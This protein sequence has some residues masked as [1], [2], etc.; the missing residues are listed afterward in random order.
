MSDRR[1]GNVRVEGDMAVIRIPIEE[2]HGFRVALASCGCVGA[3]SLG[4]EK[5]RE[6][7]ARALGKAQSLHVQRGGKLE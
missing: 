1:R 3:K 6:A 5:K 2:V 4:T 7:L